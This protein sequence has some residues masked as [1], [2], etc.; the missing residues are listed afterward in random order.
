MTTIVDLDTG[1]VLGVVDDRDH[2]GVGEWLFKRSLDWRLGVH[3][4]AIDPS[5]VFRKALRMWLPRTAV[6]VDA[7]HLVLLGND[8]L[9]EVRQR[10]TQQ[11]HG[12]RGR[13]T[14]PVRANRRLLLRAGKTLSDRG[15]DRLR[16]VFDLDDPTGKLQTAWNV[17]EQLRPAAHRLPPARRRGQGQARGT[18]RTRG[19]ARDDQ[20]LAHSLPLVERDRSPHRHRRHHREGRSEQHRHPASE[21]NGKRIRQQP[22]LH[23]PHYVQKCRQ[24]GGLIIHRTG[25][26]TTNHGELFSPADTG[27]LQPGARTLLALPVHG[28]ASRLASAD[29]LIVLSGQWMNTGRTV[30]RIA[31]F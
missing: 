25:E 28:P 31:R 23:H 29:R 4:V 17:K 10:L 2:K 9:T 5:A 16:K 7:F 20:A 15:R 3:V 13:G 26:F 8:M 12:R 27:G 19:P 24:N 22:E 14:D 18:R 1:Q 11:T 21:T 6:S 30:S